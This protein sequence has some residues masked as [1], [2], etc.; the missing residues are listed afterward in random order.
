VIPLPIVHAETD[1][2]RAVV[3]ETYHE[4]GPVRDTGTPQDP[5]VPES[6]SGSA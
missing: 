4:D 3:V 1:N 2:V 6:L 5:D